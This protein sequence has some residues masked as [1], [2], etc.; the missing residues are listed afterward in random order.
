[1][2]LDTNFSVFL[3]ANFIIDVQIYGITVCTIKRSAV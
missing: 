1:M 3:Q 2:T